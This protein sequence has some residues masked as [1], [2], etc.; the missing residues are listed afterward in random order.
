MGLR[1]RLIE[2]VLVLRCQIG[3]RSAFAEL[4][5]RYQGPLRYFVARLL[6]DPGMAEDI[7]QDTWLTVIRKIHTLRQFD[8]FSAWLYRVARNNVYKE[9]RKKKHLCLL[10]ED[11]AVPEDNEEP[12]F[13]A[14]D[15]TKVHKCLERLRLEH[16][17]VLLLRFLEQMSY[18]QISQVI[19]CKVGT[20]RSRIH[21]AKRALKREMEN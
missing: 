9:L 11:V 12:I 5:E 6:E 21:Y 10:A 1:D 19:G 8:T 3:D 15:A 18:E 14:E 17:E 7:L 13:S 2:Q 16:K 20:V 4:I